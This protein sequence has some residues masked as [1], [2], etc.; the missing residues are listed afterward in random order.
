MNN[1]F[2]AAGAIVLILGLFWLML[3]FLGG[4]QL[5]AAGITAAAAIG[6]YAGLYPDK[7]ED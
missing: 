6:S 4:G 1:V 2:Q 7:P 5:I 3:Y